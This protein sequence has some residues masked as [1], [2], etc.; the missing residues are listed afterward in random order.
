MPI[1][2]DEAGSDDEIG[3]GADEVNDDDYIEV[4]GSDED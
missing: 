3:A 4:E 2:Q 1:Y